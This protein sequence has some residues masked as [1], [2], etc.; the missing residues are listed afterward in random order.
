DASGNAYLAGVTAST[1]FPVTAKAF[2]RRFGGGEID[3]FVTKLNPRGSALVWSTYLGGS[4]DDG[5]TNGPQIDRAG[6]VYVAALTTSVD[7]PV[8]T[9]AFQPKNLG[10]AQGYD[11]VV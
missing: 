9:D 8:T 1:D 4:G 3:G 5:A 10:G 7:H 6:H 11:G 2:Q